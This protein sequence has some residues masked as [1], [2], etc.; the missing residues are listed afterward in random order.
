MYR[1]VER[2]VTV[3]VGRDAV[4]DVFSLDDRRWRCSQ[5][6]ESGDVRGLHLATDRRKRILLLHVLIR[7]HASVVRPYGVPGD[8]DVHVLVDALCPARRLLE[9]LENLDSRLLLST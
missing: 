4:V 8:R 9:V 1:P 7:H 2:A 5:V 6:D 3:E